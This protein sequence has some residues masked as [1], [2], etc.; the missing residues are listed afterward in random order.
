[1]VFAP[2]RDIRVRL[3]VLWLCPLPAL[4]QEPTARL[5][6]LVLVR[7]LVRARLVLLPRAL[8]AREL[9]RLAL[10]RA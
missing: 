9:A 1:M 7:A 2:A 6:L 8:R 5:G 10:P 3:L 4:R